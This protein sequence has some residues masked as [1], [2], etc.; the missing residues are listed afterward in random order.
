MTPGRIFPA[1]WRLGR[2]ASGLGYKIRRA[3]V[4]RNAKG[5]GD[6]WGRDDVEPYGSKDQKPTLT[7]PSM[8]LRFVAF[9]CAYW[10]INVT[11]KG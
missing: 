11:K 4:D 1:N 8:K 3:A 10:A 6:R 2:N 5:R 9:M 7:L